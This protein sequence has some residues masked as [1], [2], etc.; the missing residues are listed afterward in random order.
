MD[1]VLSTAKVEHKILLIC[2][3][4]PEKILFDGEKY[5]T[6]SYNK[7]LKWIFQNTNDL[8]N[9]KKEET[10]KKSVSSAS[11]PLTELFSEPFLKDLDLIWR[12]DSRISSPVD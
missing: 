7:V 4:F 2:S 5:R 11:V 3:M 6:N 1:E 10:D 9:K 8:H 12:I